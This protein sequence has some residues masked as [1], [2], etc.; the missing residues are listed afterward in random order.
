M[1]D[2]KIKLNKYIN[3]LSNSKST[4]S[5]LFTAYSFVYFCFP[6]TTINLTW[7]DNFK[8]HSTHLKHL[9]DFGTS[10]IFATSIFNHLT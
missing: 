9:P 5:T 4:L 8:L 10:K 7:N 3:T 6:N 2:K 1:L